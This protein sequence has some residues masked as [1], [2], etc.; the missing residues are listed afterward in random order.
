[1]RR[2]IAALVGSAATL[3]VTASAAAGT[4]TIPNACLWN[5][6][7]SWEQ[8]SLT[9]TAAAGPERASAGAPVTLSGLNARLLIS[10]EVVEI[11]FNIGYL[12]PG[13]NDIPFR[14]WI[15]IRGTNTAEGVQVREASGTARTTIATTPEGEFV[16]ATPID[17]QAALGDTQWTLGAAFPTLF[18][19]A[20]AGTLP[21]LPAGQGGASVTPTGSAFVVASIGTLSVQIDCQPGTRAADRSGPVPAPG[22]P[23]AAVVA[24]DGPPVA[25]P[26]PRPAL[27]LRSTKLR[28]AN[29]RIAVK[30]RCA[31]A[32]CKGKLSIQTA[33]K[34]TVGRRKLIVAVTRAASYSLAAGQ[35]RT[36]KLRS[37][38]AVREL[39]RKR[40]LTVRVTTVPTSGDPLSRRLTL[41][42]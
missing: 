19:Q 15:A 27:T 22:A 13:D 17:V 7:S 31:A 26:A 30:L 1:M 10:P 37:S 29:G 16:S 33:S 8:E 38:A 25:A 18:T 32:P 23:F 42:R 35:S 12:K 41:G 39:L 21:P 24:P 4:V 40:N 20:E 28:D 6:T 36:L 9:F 11:G 3:I 2:T 5:A 14:A 34:V